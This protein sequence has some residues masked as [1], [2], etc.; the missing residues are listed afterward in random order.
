MLLIPCPF[1]GARDEREFVYGGDAAAATV[2][3]AAL[4]DGEW[5]AGL[6]LRDDPK[7]RAIEHWLHRHGCRRW[8]EIDRDR[9]SHEIVSVVPARK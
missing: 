3:D 5:A 6:Y 7:G 8:L 1:C 4:G 2:P 9:T